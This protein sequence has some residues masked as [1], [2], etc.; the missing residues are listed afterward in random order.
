MSQTDDFNWDGDVNVDAAAS[1]DVGGPG[2]GTYVG[3][4]Y[5]GGDLGTWG[6]GPAWGGD[7][8]WP[9]AWQGR[10]ALLLDEGGDDK[11]NTSKP[12]WSAM[13]TRSSP[14]ADGAGRRRRHV[15]YV[16]SRIQHQTPTTPR[17]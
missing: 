13:G 3:T 16:R 4:L 9:L 15:R 7:R 1:D 10:R 6:W 5:P 12:V 8:P 14:G 11:Y 2:T 17:P